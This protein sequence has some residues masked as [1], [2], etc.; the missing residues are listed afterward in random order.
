[1]SFIQNKIG[2]M[3]KL[4]IFSLAMI[5][6]TITHAANLDS[7][8]G[9]WKT[10]DDVSGKP[11]SIVHITEAADHTLQGIVVKIYPSPGK[12]ENEVCSACRDEKHDQRIVG[13]QILTGMQLNEDRWSGGKILDPVNGKYYRCTMRVINDG[14]QLSVRGY[15][16][17]P[18]LGRSQTWNRV[19]INKKE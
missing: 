15:I 12:D 17:F 7:P 3:S 14:Q 10:I 19:D 1:M 5:I 8:I 4:V 13:M 6:S 9:Y 18:L 16:G 11:K 2:F